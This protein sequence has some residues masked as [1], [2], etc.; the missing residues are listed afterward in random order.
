MKAQKTN[1]FHLPNG[2][3]LTAIEVGKSAI[4]NRKAWVAAAMVLCVAVALNIVN[5]FADS[6][7]LRIYAHMCEFMPA[8]L[9]IGGSLSQVSARIVKV[10]DDWQ[11]WRKE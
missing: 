4:P 9:L 11:A 10:W 3:R 1:L 8:W 6:P 5:V 7:R 2:G